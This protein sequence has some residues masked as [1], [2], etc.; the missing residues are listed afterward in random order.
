MRAVRRPVRAAPV[1]DQSSSKAPAPASFLPCV[2][3]AEGG[4]TQLQPQ[5]R[6]RPAPGASAS[7]WRGGDGGPT[8]G[9]KLRRIPF[10]SG[11]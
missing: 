11:I 6:A 4:G 8:H 3:V 1:C 5:P 7:A 10:G 2:A 9:F